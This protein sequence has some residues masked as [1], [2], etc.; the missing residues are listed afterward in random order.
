ME[1][2]VQRIRSAA[3]KNLGAKLDKILGATRN[4]EKEA[5]TDK[6]FGVDTSY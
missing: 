3:E 6:S 5:A 2:E 4:I 1:L